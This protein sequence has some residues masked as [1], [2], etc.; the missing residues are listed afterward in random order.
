VREDQRR[1]GDKSKYVPFVLFN[2]DHAFKGEELE[3]LFIVVTNLGSAESRRNGV[4]AILS[5]G[6]A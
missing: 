5:D 2:S 1:R 3:G 4:T 6:P